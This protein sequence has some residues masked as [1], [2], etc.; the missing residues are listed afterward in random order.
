M[1][2]SNIYTV[3]WFHN[4]G[5]NATQIFYMHNEMSVYCNRKFELKNTKMLHKT[6]FNTILH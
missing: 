1:Y 3:P 2:A 5:L 4:E 6:W